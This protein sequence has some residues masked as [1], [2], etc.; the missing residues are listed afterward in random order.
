[1]NKRSK[2]A[3]SSLLKLPNYL[4]P[5]V[6]RYLSMYDIFNFASVANV[7][8]LLP[9]IIALVKDSWKGF[10]YRITNTINPC[11]YSFKDKNYADLYEKHIGLDR[12]ENNSGA[13]RICVTNRELMNSDDYISI[14]EP[15][16]RVQNSDSYAVKGMIVQIPANYTL[17]KYTYMCIDNILYGTRATLDK[18]NMQFKVPYNCIVEQYLLIQNNIIDRCVLKHPIG[19]VVPANE[20]CEYY[21]PHPYEYLCMK[22]K[23]SEEFA[24]F[25]DLVIYN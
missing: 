8:F 6:N 1:M 3:K 24:Q 10:D 21:N 5:N 16:V 25:H 20:P 22:K 17:V 15:H 9:P 4:W 11:M 19:G 14:I 2:V 12:I 13:A 23:L 18:Y 7:K